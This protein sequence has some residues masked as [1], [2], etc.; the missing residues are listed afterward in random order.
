ML[1][2]LL[3]TLA[4]SLAAPAKT[5]VLNHV[6]LIDGTGGAAVED[7][8][9]VIG[10]NGR[11]RYAGPAAQAQI[12]SDADVLDLGGKTVV[13]GIINMHG[14]VGNVKGVVQD[15]S[16]FTREN[17]IR[18]L[19]DYAM[20]G[21]TTTTSMGTDE[22]LMIE[23]R[24]ERRRDAFQSARVF[25]ALQG[26]TT[27]D[28]YPTMA[29]GVKGVA[30]ETATAAQARAWV[31]K[32]A[33][34]G[35]DIVKTWI[36]SHHGEFQ[37]VP[38]PVYE[39]IIK[40]AKRRGR[41]SFVHIYELEDAKGAAK[42]GVNIIGH[43]V[44]DAEVDDELVSL[45]IKNDVTYVPTI[46]REVSTF[47]Y[48]D[49]PAW[50]DDPFFRRAVDNETVQA[51]KTRLKAAQSDPKIVAQGKEDQRMAML[52]VKK[53]HDAGVRIGFG[54]DTGPPGRF[55]GFFEHMEAELMV[56]AGIQPMDVIVTWS[57]NAAKALRIEKDFGTL[58]KGKTADLVVLDANPLENIR[59]TRK[60][61]AVYMSGKKFE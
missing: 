6:R 28:G 26:F 7:A 8:A 33:D 58:E 45:L 30:Q 3:L 48:H 17:V 16:N 18:N 1:R 9:I 61:H 15:R 34:K 12:P 60:I 52:N 44:R 35:A 56:E 50:L 36:D 40:Q 46:M 11:I 37:K 43:S 31:D 22:D 10:D 59:N 53:L 25:T 39:A 4:F 21:V 51:V 38:P 24:D 23:I 2:L 55:A 20:Y 19:R 29:P 57:R 54:T 42:A 49:P 5:L 14:H 32:L 41:L 13:P 47:I 27:P